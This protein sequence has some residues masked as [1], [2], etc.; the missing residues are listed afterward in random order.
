[1]RRWHFDNCTGPTKYFKAR[2]TLN[3]ERIHLGKFAT[4]EEAKA[5][6]DAF[7]RE[8]PR[9]N[10][11]KGRKHSEAS[12]QKMSASQKGHPGNV[13]S[14]EAKQKLAEKHTGEKNPFYGRKHTEETRKIITEKNIGREGYWTG[15]KFSDDHLAKLK[16]NRTCPHCNKSGS[17][18]A[19][20]RYHMDNCKFKAEAA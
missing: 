1:M 14:A 3:G 8:H 16:I 6:V 9:P 13:W 4:N 17:G 10:V 12:R 20:N 18:S 19:M 7:Y 2:A 15:K 11:W 5:V